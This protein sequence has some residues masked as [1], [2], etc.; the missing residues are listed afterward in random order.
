MLTK[1]IFN[2]TINV[3]HILLLMLT[4]FAPYMDINYMSRLVY[5]STL[6]L[7][8]LCSKPYT[9]HVFYFRQQ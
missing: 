2:G 5:I 4:S 6:S 3:S 7:R 1:T 8:A 9:V